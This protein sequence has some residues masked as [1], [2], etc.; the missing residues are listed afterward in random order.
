MEYR[1]DHCKKNYSSYQSLWI[2]NKK[3]HTNIDIDVNKNV[4]TVNVCV[5][6]NVNTVNI[7][8]ATKV[9]QYFCSKCD[10]VFNLRQGRYQHEKNCK[11]NKEENKDKEIKQLEL[12]LKKKEE[13]NIKIREE[14]TNAIIEIKKEFVDL[15]KKNGNVSSENLKQ[16]NNKVQKVN[17]KYGTNNVNNGQI[18]N[19]TYVKFGNLDYKKIFSDKE[20]CKMMTTFQYKVLEEFIKKTHFNDNHPEYNNIFITN[21]RSNIAF[22]FDG[23]E[24][25]ATD[26]NDVLNELISDHTNE[27]NLSLDIHRKKLNNY[28]IKKIEGMLKKLESEDKFVDENNNK[29]FNNYKVYKMNTIKTDIYNLSDRKKLELLQ[30]MQLFEKTYELSEESE[31]EEDT[32]DVNNTVSSKKKKKN[33]EITI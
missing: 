5:N 3:F 27:I 13:E 31:C 15:I 20:I 23:K 26:K 1:C 17:N 30:N 2:H 21:L 28:T 22:I 29:S 32:T 14:F 8:H 24:F 25:I 18:I 7:K 4:N 33:I 9:K 11:V 16:I 19:N 10:K 6:T 12:E